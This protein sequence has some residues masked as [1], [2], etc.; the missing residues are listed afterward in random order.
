MSVAPSGS[1]HI[2]IIEDVPAAEVARVSSEFR[3]SGAVEV[4]TEAQPDGSWRVVATFR[5]L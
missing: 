5:D 2:E 1:E 3:E 4:T